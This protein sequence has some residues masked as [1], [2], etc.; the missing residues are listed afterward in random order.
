MSPTLLTRGLLIGVLVV[1]VVVALAF[2]RHQNAERRMGGAISLA[3]MFWLSFAVGVWFLVCPI[4]ALDTSVHLGLR[5]ILGCFAAFMWMRGVVELFMMYVTRNW[6]PPYGIA[7][8]VSSI[9]LLVVASGWQFN[10]LRTIGAG[11]DLWVLALLGVV[12]ASLVLEVGYA[13]AFYRVV[14][15]R[16]V[17]GEAVW[18]ASASDEQFRKI[19]QVTTAFNILLYMFLVAFVLVSVVGGGG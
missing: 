3:K 6:R 8:S 5:W 18:Y 13:A 2:Y 10:S 11:Y 1:L 15:E 4:L 7:H 12:L 17:G 16:T 19:N 14:G 9:V